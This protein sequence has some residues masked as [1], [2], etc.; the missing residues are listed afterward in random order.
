[1]RFGPLPLPECEGGILAHTFKSDRITLKKGTIL[2][3]EHLHQIAACGATSLIV[4][5]LDEDDIDENLAASRLADALKVESIEIAGAGTGRVNFY[6]SSNGVFCPSSELINALNA[7]DPGITFATL[8]NHEPVLAGRMLA[9][10]K[11]IPYGVR[12]TSVE[13]IEKIAATNPAMKVQPFVPRRIGVIS[14][15]LPGLK[16]Q[17]IEKTVSILEKRLADTGSTIVANQV[18]GHESDSV[19]VCIASQVADDCEMII[20]FGASATSDEHDVVPAALRE[21]GGKVIRYGMP[22]DPGNLLLLGNIGKI[23]VIGAPGCARSPAENG[24][25]HVL[26]RLLAGI[27]ITSDDIAAMGVGG[28]LMEIGSRPQPRQSADTPIP[29]IAALVLA[30]GK[31]SRMGGT[32]KMSTLVR[33]KPMVR[34]VVEAALDAD[35]KTLVITGHQDEKVREA[36]AG[37]DVVFCHNADYRSGLSTSLRT[38]IL[39]L[40]PAVSHAFILLG[41]MPGITSQMLE[42]MSAMAEKSPPNAIVLATSGGQRGNPVLWPRGYFEELASLSGDAG[43]RHLLEQYRENVIEI[44]LG[45]AAAL[46]IDTPEALAKLEAQAS[47]K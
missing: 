6:A 30:A 4:A 36:L 3:S 9:T 41:D 7:V 28:L 35:C 21:A 20:V 22:V 33:G 31:G 46:D 32:N 1:M 17:T 14:T 47:T 10:I 40:D 19:A 34:H 2:T 45:N 25:D 24:F 16:N 37:S 43:A 29:R 42:N 12:R 38:G 26:Q 44:E 18:T 27:A 39:A 15:R 5:L 23:D 8:K 13:A 11:I